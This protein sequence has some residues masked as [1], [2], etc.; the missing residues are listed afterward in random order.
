LSA[1]TVPVSTPSSYERISLGQRWTRLRKFAR[2]RRAIAT[3]EIF[4]GSY[5]EGQPIVTLV[6]KNLTDYD[7]AALAHRGVGVQHPDAFLVGLFRQFPAEVS[8]AFRDMRL[9]SQPEPPAMLERL[10]KDGQEQ[11][12]ALLQTG[13]E[14]GQFEL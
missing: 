8:T 4:A 13:S 5:Y 6:T 11:L 1:P 7:T 14:Q 12:A 3:R 9:A 2:G 10:A